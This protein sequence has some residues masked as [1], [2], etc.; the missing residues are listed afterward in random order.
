MKVREAHKKLTELMEQGHSEVE[1]FTYYVEPGGEA[2]GFYLSKKQ[3]HYDCGELCDLP[4]GT[5]VVLIHSHH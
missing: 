5:S 4:N 3:D 2:S 1:M